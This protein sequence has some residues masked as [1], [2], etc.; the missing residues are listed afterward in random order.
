MP[1][2]IRIVSVSLGPSSRDSSVELELLGERF[3]L[4][5]LGTDANIERFARF[6]RQYDGIADVLCL[7]GINLG[8]HWGNRFYPFT[9]V[10]NILRHVKQ[11]PVVDGTGLKATLEPMTLDFLQQ[12]GITDLAQTRTLMMD[13]FARHWLARA[14]ASSCAEVVYG[15][16]MFSFNIPLPIRSLKAMNFWARTLLPMIARLPHNWA[17]T[18]GVHGNTIVGGF[19]NYYQWADL[20]AGDFTYIRHYMPDQLKGKIILTNTITN[21]DIALLRERGIRYL[22]TSTPEI[23][24]RTFATNVME[25]VFVSLLG[26]PPGELSA[27]DYVQLAEDINWQPLVREISPA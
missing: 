12:Q 17:F 10:G 16:L 4:E 2:M 3:L 1:G 8:I 9:Q 24:G 15:D 19:D 14:I 21:E 20:I 22:V 18:T 23:E 7:G 5:R 13:A 26:R 6:L 11:T 25:G 27:R